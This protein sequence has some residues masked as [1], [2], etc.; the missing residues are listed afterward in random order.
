LLLVVKIKRKSPE[1]PPQ[2]QGVLR[3]AEGSKRLIL[4]TSDV[5]DSNFG[6]L[7]G[8]P[9][10][11]VALTGF[12]F[13]LPIRR[14]HAD[15]SFSNQ[16]G[17][18]NEFL[19]NGGPSGSNLPIDTTPGWSVA[20]VSGTPHDLNYDIIASD[21]NYAFTHFTY[22]Y[23][24]TRILGGGVFELTYSPSV[25][26]LRQANF[27]RLTASASNG[28]GAYIERG[29]LIYAYSPR[30]TNAVPEPST[31]AMMLL[32]FTSLGFAGYRRARK[33]P[34]S[35][36]VAPTP[37]SCPLRRWVS[38]LREVVGGTAFAPRPQRNGR[39]ARMGEPA[40]RGEVSGRPS[41]C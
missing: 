37:P 12:D 40:A 7:Y 6:Y 34:E 14:N 41:A 26:L 9:F 30:R 20:S 25:D 1:H 36:A 8:E 31:W 18:P 27:R 22:V 33:S 3:L 39:R 29:T 21:E 4:S 28:E 10:D 23:G 17:V 5:A 11:L 19:A 15:P 16:Y 2:F 24:A 35:A 13:S 32:G 38:D